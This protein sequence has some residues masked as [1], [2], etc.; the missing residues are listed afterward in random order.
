MQRRYWTSITGIQAVFIIIYIIGNRICIG[1]GVQNLSELMIR[2]RNIA[3]VNIIP[4]FLGGWRSFGAGQLG[5]PLYVYYLAHYCVGRMVV[6]QGVLHAV[7]AVI[8]DQL[9]K[10]DIQKVSGITVSTLSGIWLR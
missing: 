8:I 5:L 2:S 3:F 1:A 6:L 4:L 10:L 7:L 9:W